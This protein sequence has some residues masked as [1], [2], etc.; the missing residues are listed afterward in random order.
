MWDEAANFLVIQKDKSISL[1]DPLDHIEPPSVFYTE[2]KT[3][4]TENISSSPRSMTDA[5]EK[6]ILN[7][8]LNN[9]RW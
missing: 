7:S 3:S 8:D 2:Y 6:I 9:R 1:N 4:N 5:I